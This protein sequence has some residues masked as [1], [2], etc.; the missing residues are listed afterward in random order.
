MERERRLVGRG[1][2]ALAQLHHALERAEGGM[3]T[4]V[5]IEGAAGMGKTVV[6]RTFLGRL[7]RDVLRCTGTAQPQLHVPFLPLTSAFDALGIARHQRLASASML[8]SEIDVQ[9]FADV[10]ASLL[11]TAR[12]RTVVLAFD[13]VQWLDD[14]TCK[15]LSF[16]PRRPSVTAPWTGRSASSPC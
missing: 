13:D 9:L 6:L 11:A 14:A 16:V 2:R 12:T 7:H 5:G 8:E 15:L 1:A 10:T 3:P 4:V